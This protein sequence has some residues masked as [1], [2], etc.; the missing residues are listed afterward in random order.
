MMCEKITTNNKII[1]LYTI[2]KHIIRRGAG[3]SNHP[4]RKNLSKPLVTIS[5]L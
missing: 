2:E 3:G 1:A 5:T 4:K